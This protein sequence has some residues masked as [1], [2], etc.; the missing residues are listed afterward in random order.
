[1]DTVKTGTAFGVVNPSGAVYSGIKTWNS[2]STIL[3][4]THTVGDSFAQNTQYA[5]SIDTTAADIY[6]KAVAKKFI[7]MF[8]TGT[9]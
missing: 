8:T 1:M 5:A 7:A 6:G 3:T 4:F 2:T 9:R